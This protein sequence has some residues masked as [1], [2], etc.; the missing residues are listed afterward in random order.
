MAFLVLTVCRIVWQINTMATVYQP[1]LLSAEPY[2]D[3]MFC[4]HSIQL[5]SGHI[6]EKKKTENKIGHLLARAKIKMQGNSPTHFISYIIR[7][8][9]WIIKRLIYWPWARPIS[10]GF[11][12][13]IPTLAFPH[14]L[15]THSIALSFTHL[16]SPNN[17]ERVR[18]VSGSITI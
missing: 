7:M 18:R 14:L 16:I 6:C 8:C 2:H 3:L 15:L 5:S 9:D 10:I 12:N 17:N 1:K 13:P 11:G 4:L